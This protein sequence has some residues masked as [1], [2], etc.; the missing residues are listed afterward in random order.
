VGAGAPT[1][2]SHGGR[3][4]GAGSGQSRKSSCHSKIPHTT[5]R[6]NFPLCTQVHGSR[7]ALRPFIGLA[8][9]LTPAPSTGPTGP[10]GTRGPTPV[11]QHLCSWLKVTVIPTFSLP[12]G[13]RPWGGFG[14]PGFWSSRRRLI[15]RALE[16][17]GSA[18]RPQGRHAVKDNSKEKAPKTKSQQYGVL[19]LEQG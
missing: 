4:E 15:G 9:L 13:G 7:M 11:H 6:M 2:V 14:S 1:Y 3:R 5:L 18:G 19:L 17:C 10:P 8:S 12:R 16:R